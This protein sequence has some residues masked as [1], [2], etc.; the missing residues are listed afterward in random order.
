MY[1]KKLYNRKR[2]FTIAYE[3]KQQYIIDQSFIKPLGDVPTLAAC[4]VI[5]LQNCNTRLRKA[6]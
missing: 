2:E 5:R 1:K 4:L 6:Y 3:L